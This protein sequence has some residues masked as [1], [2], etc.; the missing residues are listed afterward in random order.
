M[1]YRTVVV[2]LEHAKIQ[3]EHFSMHICVTVKLSLMLY[4]FFMMM[5][6]NIEAV[7]HTIMY[8]YTD[9]QTDNQPASL[10]ASQP[11][12]LMI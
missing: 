1:L 11:V 9:R 7:V 8:E 3:C 6:L 4:N 2:I 12:S 5:H 10:L